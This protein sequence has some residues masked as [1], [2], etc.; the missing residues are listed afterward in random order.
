MAKVFEDGPALG[1]L[2]IEEGPLEFTRDSV[3]IVNPLDDAAEEADRIAVDLPIGYPVKDDGTPVLAASL[4][5]ATGIILNRTQLENEE[6]ALRAVLKR[7]HFVIN[8]AKLPAE[9]Y[10]GTAFDLPTFVAM[11]A[12]LGGI[13]RA[14]APHSTQQDT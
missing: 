9:D 1:D 5:D 7:G 11:L 14:E 2:L 6:T 4:M 3:R 12:G 10:A 13:C 8:K